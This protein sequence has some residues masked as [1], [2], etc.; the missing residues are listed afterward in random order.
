LP[1]YSPHL[2][3]I[4][5]WW[6]IIKQKVRNYLTFNDILF[7]DAMSI[8][9]GSLADWCFEEKIISEITI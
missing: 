2:N 5:N 9:F 7:G 6:A 3:K 4:E 1:P 8:V